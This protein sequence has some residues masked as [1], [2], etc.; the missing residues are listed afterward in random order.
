MMQ[1]LVHLLMDVFILTAL[2][3][4]V[5]SH[6]STSIIHALQNLVVIKVTF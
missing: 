3:F 5:S 4:I 1:I 2:P 6:G